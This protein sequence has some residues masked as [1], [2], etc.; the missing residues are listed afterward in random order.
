MQEITPKLWESIDIIMSCLHMLSDLVK[1]LNVNRDVFSK[2]ILNYSTTTEL[3]NLLV[4]KYSIPFRVSHKIVGSIVKTL[5][6]KKL[7]I[8]DLTPELLDNTIKDYT[9]IIIT[10][11]IEDIKTTINPKNCVESHKTLG[12]PAPEE[13]KRVLF[14]SKRMNKQS[15]IFQKELKSRLEEADEHLKSLVQRYKIS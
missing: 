6:D 10:T 12:G 11:K 14:N 8:S 3:A 15:K 13:V 2:Q 5:I 9:G 1:E 4:K 7:T